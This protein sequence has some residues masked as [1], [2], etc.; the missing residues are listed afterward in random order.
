M[1]GVAL[2]RVSQ[3]G[4]KLL[5]RIDSAALEQTARQDAQPPCHWV[6]P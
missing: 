6:E 3:A 5:G 2:K 4:C 1:S